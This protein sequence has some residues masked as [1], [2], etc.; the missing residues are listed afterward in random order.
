MNEEMKWM[1]EW[2]EM[3]WSDMNWIEIKWMNGMNEFNWVE[4]EIDLN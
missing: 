4:I 2:F 1:N 3:K